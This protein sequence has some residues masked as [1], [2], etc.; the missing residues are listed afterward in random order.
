MAFSAGELAN[1]SAAALDFHL[2]KGTVHSQSIQEKPLLKALKSKQKSFPGGK[3]DITVRV[4]GAYTTTIQ[5]FT[6][7][8]TVSYDNPANIKTATYAWKE[9]HAGIQITET[10]LKKVG[11]GLTESKIASASTASQAEQVALANLLD[12]K[13]EDLSEGWARGMNAMYWADGSQ[14]AKE[15]P[16]IKSF[17]LDDPTS[18]VTVGGIDQVAN[19][20]WRNRAA[21]GIASNSSTWANQPLILRLIKEERQLRR[22][23]GKPNLRLAGSD[24][25]DALE[26]ELRSKGNWT[27]SGWASQGSMD[28]SEVDKRL[29]GSVFMYDPTLDDLSEAK[30]AYMFDTRH[31]YPMVMDGEDMKTHNPARPAEQYVTYRAVTWTGGLICRQRNSQAVISIA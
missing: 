27:Q 26:G 4:K 14:D 30:R 22:Y 20:W 23:G 5:G 25:L 17:I 18:A 13:L 1:I 28:L 12:D 29:E 24:F 10:E 6:H 31:F 15:V 2:N 21:L 11:I 7:D 9:I 16:G 19:T 3:D 8:D